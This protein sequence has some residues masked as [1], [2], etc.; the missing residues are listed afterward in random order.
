[1]SGVLR[2][3]IRLDTGLRPDITV[4]VRMDPENKA[5]RDHYLL[6]WIDVGQSPQLRL[7]EDN[8]LFLDAYRFETLDPLFY[9]S[10]RHTLRSAA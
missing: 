9:L 3:K 2:W 10:S 8:G 4:A 7:A 5:A 1:M 6:P